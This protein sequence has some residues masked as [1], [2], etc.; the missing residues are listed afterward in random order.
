MATLFNPEQRMQ[1]FNRHWKTPTLERHKRRLLPA[2]KREWIQFYKPK[3]K[4]LPQPLQNDNQPAFLD[5]QLGQ[6]P[7]PINSKK[8]MTMHW[9]N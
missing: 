9:C 8:R 3:D 4:D 2:I 5:E 1:Y 7:I 6:V